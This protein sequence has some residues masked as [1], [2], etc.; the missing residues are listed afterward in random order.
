METKEKVNEKIDVQ[1]NNINDK[2]N[3]NK[4][5]VVKGVFNIISNIFQIIVWILI[6]IAVSLLVFFSASKKT[7]CF[8]YRMLIVVTGSMEPTIH[9]KQAIIVKQNDNPQLGEILAF[10]ASEDF[11]TVHRIIGIEKNGDEILYKTKGDNNNIE[12]KELVKKAEVRGTVKYILPAVGEVILY[13]QSHMYILFF[14][15]GILVIFILVRRVL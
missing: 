13:L 8:G 12:D 1:N 4:K 6:I 7:D 3:K 5:S 9:V 10:G 2:N 14:A 15:I 11:I